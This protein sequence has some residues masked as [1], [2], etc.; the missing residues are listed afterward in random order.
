MRLPADEDFCGRCGASAPSP[1]GEWDRERN[2][3]VAKDVARLECFR[4]KPV[5]LPRADEDADDQKVGHVLSGS[6]SGRAS[7]RAYGVASDHAPAGMMDTRGP[8]DRDRPIPPG[9]TD[10]R[11]ALV[12]KLRGL[13][14]NGLARIAEVYGVGEE[15]AA[16]LLGERLGLPACQ[17]LSWVR[18]ASVGAPIASWWCPTIEALECRSRTSERMGSNGC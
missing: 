1:D 3:A 14:R 10:P 13:A 18:N 8:V 17:L 15:E 2:L 5:D 11:P 6:G 16:G 7:A 4:A 9:V 12:L